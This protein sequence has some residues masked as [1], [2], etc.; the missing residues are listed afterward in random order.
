MC[1]LSLM[2]T[3]LAVILCCAQSTPCR[4]LHTGLKAFIHTQLP[5]HSAH[6]I[7]KLWKTVVAKLTTNGQRQ[8]FTADLPSHSWHLDSRKSWYFGVKKNLP[9]ILFPQPDFFLSELLTSTCV[10]CTAGTNHYWP[11]CHQRGSSQGIM[12]MYSGKVW[13]LFQC[14][15]SSNPGNPRGSTQ[16]LCTYHH[17][18]T[19]A[20]SNIQFK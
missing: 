2:G 12:Y 17:W 6:L 7:S 13:P 19:K 10:S 16:L 18:G 4:S 15:T 1:S 14:C 5:S 3:L 11:E 8:P 9:H 20:V